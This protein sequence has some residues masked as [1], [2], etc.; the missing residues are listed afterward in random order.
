MNTQTGIYCQHEVEA[1]PQLRAAADRL[2]S[3]IN[4]EAYVPYEPFPLKGSVTRLFLKCSRFWSTERLPDGLV[5]FLRTCHQ[6]T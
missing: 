6:V 5:Q 4:Y 1:Q 2:F 3:G